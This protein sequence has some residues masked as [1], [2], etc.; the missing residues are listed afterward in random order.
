MLKSATTQFVIF[1][2]LCLSLSQPVLTQTS[3]PA[4]SEKPAARSTSKKPDLKKVV[5]QNERQYRERSESVDVK[6][7]E[8]IE[9]QQPKG[10]GLTGRQKAYIALAI[11]GVAA[12]VFVLVKYGKECLKTDP[13]GCDP[14][15]DTG[16]TCTQ[17][18]QNL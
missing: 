10:H 7:L 8:K 1:A 5:A 17:Y 4:A 12:L 6:A 14:Y 9:R 3:E 16:C 13:A 15:S 18:K 2:V 11:I